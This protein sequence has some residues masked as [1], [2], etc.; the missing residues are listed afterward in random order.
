M[1][2]GDRTDVDTWEATPAGHVRV[3]V[4][5]S[6]S[7]PY[8][9]GTAEYAEVPADTADHWDSRIWRDTP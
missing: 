5:G 2:R 6:E 4:R 8:A 7:F 1:G 3:Q 9:D